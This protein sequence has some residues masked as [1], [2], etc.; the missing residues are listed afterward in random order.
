MSNLSAFM[1]ANVEQIENYKFAASPRFKGED[2]KPMLWEICCISADEYARIRN[3]CVRQVPVPGKKGQY[4]QQL[5]TYTFQAKVAARCTVFPDLNNAALQNDW[6][7]AKP[8]ELIGKLLIGG[9]F[10]DYVTEVFQVNG[11]KTDDDVVAEAK[12]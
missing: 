5:D 9:E 12:N 3:S 8:E 1:H 4:T 10:D 6:G 2:G 7:V 11:F